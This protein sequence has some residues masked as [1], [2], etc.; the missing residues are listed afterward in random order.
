MLAANLERRGKLAIAPWALGYVTFGQSPHTSRPSPRKITIKP[1]GRLGLHNRGHFCNVLRKKDLF[2]GLSV[3]KHKPHSRGSRPGFTRARVAFF[4]G[5][6]LARSD[7]LQFHHS[8]FVTLLKALL[9]I[10]LG[11]AVASPQDWVGR[12][13]LSLSK[14][15]KKPWPGYEQTART[16]CRTSACV[17]E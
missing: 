3:Q 10:D 5:E 16:M 6:V 11:Y 12:L 2:L 1:G 8:I 7:H 14:I 4:S 9:A 17:N 15:A 13:S